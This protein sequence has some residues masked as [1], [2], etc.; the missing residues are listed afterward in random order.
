MGPRLLFYKLRK[1]IVDLTAQ[2]GKQT[3]LR[4]CKIGKYV[5]I[6]SHC[7]L[8][9]VTIGNYTCIASTAAIGGMEHSYW[10][11]SISP[12]L[13]NE[14]VFGHETIIGN[15][16]W[17]GAHVC[18]K[19]GVSIGDGAVIGAGSVVT[20][21]IPPYTIAYGIPAKVIKR[22]F[23]DEEKEQVIKESKFWEKRPDEARKIIMQIVNNDF[24]KR[25]YDNCNNANL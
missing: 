18:V 4:S 7:V 21:D 5:Y 1:N 12:V 3:H 23:E 25:Q 22:R 15:D 11:P 19:Q 14:C 17:I 13:S 20:H 16:V 6:G 24:N 8:N 10:Y 2:I 9:H